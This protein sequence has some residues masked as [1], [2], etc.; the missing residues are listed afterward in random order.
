MCTALAMSGKDRYFGRNLDLE[1]SYIETIT[2][3]PR[4]FP[5]AFRK[6]ETIAHHYAMIGTAYVR[7]GY[8]LYY[9][10]T[11]EKGLSMAGLNFPGN[12]VYKPY[13]I[14]REN[15]APFELIP[16]ILGQCATVKEAKEK[17]SA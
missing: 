10:A 17:L 2:I 9:D 7:D 16:W 4:N 13:V 8:P 5:F 6:K 14:G 12:A 15:V 1:Y 3:T 11:N